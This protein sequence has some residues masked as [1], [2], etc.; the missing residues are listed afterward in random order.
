MNIELMFEIQHNALSVDRN[1]L[2]TWLT[3]WCTVCVYSLSQ[4]CNLQVTD[5]ITSSSVWQILAQPFTHLLWGT[6]RCVVS[7]LALCLTE[8]QSLS[9]VLASTTEHFAS[10]TLLSSFRWLTTAWMSVKSKSSNLVVLLAKTLFL[11]RNTRSWAIADDLR[12]VYASIVWFGFHEFT[13][14]TK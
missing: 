9:T 11:L 2:W 12:D 1:Q 6:T 10:D 8:P 14:S 5:P 7:I 13:G 4:T 3:N